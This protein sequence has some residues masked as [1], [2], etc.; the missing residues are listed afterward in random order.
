MS[1]LHLL[2]GTTWGILFQ[3]CLLSLCIVAGV[4]LYYAICHFERGNENYVIENNTVQVDPVPVYAYKPAL[5]TPRQGEN[6]GRDVL[7]VY[8]QNSHQL[9]SV[10]T[11]KGSQNKQQTNHENQVQV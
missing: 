10:Y 5:C 11:H 6:Y 8:P 2:F 7:L 3:L 9:Y 4:M 1:V